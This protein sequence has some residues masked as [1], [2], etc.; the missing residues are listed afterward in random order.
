[1]QL[2]RSSEMV[3]RD[4]VQRAVV[5]KARYGVPRVLMVTSSRYSEQAVMAANSNGVTL[6]NRST[7]AV[8]L[9]LFDAYPPS[10]GVKRWASDL[11]AGTRICLNAVAALFIAVLAFSAKDKRRE[12]TRSARV[13]SQ[14]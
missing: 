10:S 13:S 5:A 12:R 4:A 7:L 11:Q 1:M 9:S 2:K 3:P 6:W 14:P 8:E